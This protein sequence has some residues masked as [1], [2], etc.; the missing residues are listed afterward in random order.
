MHELLL[1]ADGFYDDVF[2]SLGVPYEAVQW[3]RDVNPV[4]REQAMLEKQ[5]AVDTLIRV[6]RVRGHLIADLDPLASKSRTWT[7]SSTR[8]RTG[9]RSGTSSASS[10]RTAWPAPTA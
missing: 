9:S 7:T 5:M 1:G 4:D 2:R 6:Y 10:S 8:R 3:R